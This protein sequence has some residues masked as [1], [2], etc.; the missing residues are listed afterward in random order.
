MAE[1]RSPPPPREG[2]ASAGID[3]R[4]HPVPGARPIRR[5]T[6]TERCRQ[7]R[8]INASMVR[9][10]LGSPHVTADAPSGASRRSPAPTVPRHSSRRILDTGKTWF[11]KAENPVSPVGYQASSAAGDTLGLSHR[12]SLCNNQ[13]LPRRAHPAKSLRFLGNCRRPESR[14]FPCANNQSATRSRHNCR[15][16]ARFW[17]GF[18]WIGCRLH[19]N[20]WISQKMTQGQEHCA[21]RIA[22]SATGC[23]HLPAMILG[24]C[25]RRDSNSHTLRRRILNPL[26][27]PFRH[28]GPGAVSLPGGGWSTGQRLPE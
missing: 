17:P 4:G 7:N 15:A 28:S 18:V 24:W 26:R 22:E 2:A 1:P 8:R 14:C 5:R 12:V 21:L 11:Q 20:G 25:P 3:P 19:A 9:S 6:T 10:N 16:S 23:R 13:S 27:L